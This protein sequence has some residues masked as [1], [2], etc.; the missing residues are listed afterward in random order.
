ML[1]P[2]RSADVWPRS[3]MAVAGGILLSACI[4]LWWPWL[5]GAVTIPWDAKSQF[6]PQ[7]VF[8]AR[9][10]AA[11]DSPFWTPNVFAGW[12]QVAD[13]Q[14]LIFSP[15][16][17]LLALAGPAPGFRAFDA[18]AFAA[19]FLGGLGI[20]LLFRDRGWHPAGAL[21]AA[22]AFVAGGSCA[23]RIQ[24]IGQIM[25]VGYFPLALWALSRALD[26]G[27]ARWGVGA[28]LLAALVALGRDQVALLALYTLAGF[29]LA[30]WLT[31]EDR[32]VRLRRSLRPLAAGALAG[33][34]V[35]ALPTLLTALLAAESNRPEIEI[36]EA[37]RGSLHPAHLLTFAFA[38][39]FGANDPAVPYWGPAS[40]PWG[41]TGLV[42]AQNMGQLYQGALPLVAILGI[43]LARGAL[44]RREIRF[45]VLATVLVLLYALGWYT[46]AFRAFYLLPGVDL[47]RRPAD[48][49]FLLAALAAILAGY[50]VD[51]WLGAMPAMQRPQRIATLAIAMLVTVSAVAVA[52]RT[53][54]LQQAA[55][56]LAA[57]L[58][59][60]FAAAIALR[61]A[62]RFGARPLRAAMILTVFTVADLGW[63]NRPNESTGLP[64][65]FYDAL[66]P[67]SADPTLQALRAR[68]ADDRSGARPRVELTGIAYHWPNAGLVHGLD[69]LFGHNPLRLAGFAR[70]TGV[71]DTVAAADQRGFAPLFPSYRSALADLFGL[72]FIATGVPIGEIDRKLLPADFP[73][74]A[75]TP[76]AFVYE[77]RRAL[78]R[79]LLLTDWRQADFGALIAHGWPDIDPRRTVLLE[80]APSPTPVPDAAAGDARLVRYANTEI[81]VEAEAPGGGLLLLNDVWHPWWRAT[82][83]GQPAEILKANALFRAVALPPG[84]HA[85]RFSFHPFRGAFAQLVGRL[86]FG[87]SAPPR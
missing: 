47:F 1:S 4:V 11:G 71:G 43:G 65:A 23:A 28:G 36:A 82:V 26:R 56:P 59:T 75:R 53:G 20:I 17:V 80:R 46:P 29:V 61:L 13:P 54:A 86:G 8:L 51:R 40:F 57:G 45:F 18:V 42:L 38:D 37:G 48:A 19:L 84:R 66:R 2:R 74:L 44:M 12:P 87:V 6:Y 70:A 52:L 34:A 73:L 63:N 3:S 24:H 32:L 30:H 68:L 41:Q 76:A 27:S 15:L 78:P 31:G 64:P 69:H 14:S 7:Q 5:S 33:A 9:A 60:A 77:N 55:L 67:D 79:V 35:V 62:D 58:A 22:L 10:L 50:C 83:D 21:V 81:V 39:L 49:S 72:R 85:V 25:S 16:H